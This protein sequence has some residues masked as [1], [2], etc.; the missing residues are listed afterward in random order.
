MFSLLNDHVL[1]VEEEKKNHKLKLRN[2]ILKRFF[3]FRCRAHTS[4][5]NNKSTNRISK[6]NHLEKLL[7][8][9]GM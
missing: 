6:R 7:Q 1:D 2:I 4:Y 9:Q 8:F 3:L 5:I